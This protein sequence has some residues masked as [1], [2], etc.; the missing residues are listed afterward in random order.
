MGDFLNFVDMGKV[1]VI[2][3]YQHVYAHSKDV[4]FRTLLNVV[5]I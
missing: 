5:N 1:T 3:I 4:G 2:Y